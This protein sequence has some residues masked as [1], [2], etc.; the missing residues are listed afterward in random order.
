MSL[1]LTK[2]VLRLLVM[3]KLFSSRF[4]AAYEAAF[5]SRETKYRGAGFREG[6]P[7]AFYAT[8]ILD[9]PTPNLE[10]HIVWDFTAIQHY[11]T[12]FPQREEALLEHGVKAAQEV[13]YQG[14]PL[15]EERYWHTFNQACRNAEI[16]HQVNEGLQGEE[17]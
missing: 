17:G 16:Q 9:A 13:T 1:P 11:L 5:V 8:D 6:L 3:K 7:M 4:R 12:H 2:R 15:G 10:Q 14:R